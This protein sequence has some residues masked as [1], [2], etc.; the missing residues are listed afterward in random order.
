V[1]SD[2]YHDKPGWFEALASS[3]SPR[4][5]SPALAAACR[6]CTIDTAPRRLD[7]PSDHAPVVCDHA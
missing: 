1:N 5:R 3:A 6:A 4:V 7:R 2:K